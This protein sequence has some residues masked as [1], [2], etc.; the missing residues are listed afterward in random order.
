MGGSINS[1]DTGVNQINYGTDTALDGSSGLTLSIWLKSDDTDDNQYLISKFTGFTDSSYALAFDSNSFEMFV[2]GSLNRVIWETDPAVV[3]TAG[4]WVHYAGTWD[5]NGSVG[6]IVLYVNGIEKPG[7][8]RNGSLTG[9]GTIKTTT[10]DIRVGGVLN[11]TYTVDGLMAHAQVFNRALPAEEILEIM[12]KPGSIQQGLVYH[13]PLTDYNN[14]SDVQGNL[15]DGTITGTMS[16][17][18][19]GPPVYFPKLEQGN[20]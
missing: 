16:E 20:G 4:E 11:T 10:A 5:Y 12:Y 13:M 2:R 8:V 19:E 6:T 7:I 15:P 14:L 9:T 1:Q 17:S 18:S 3:P